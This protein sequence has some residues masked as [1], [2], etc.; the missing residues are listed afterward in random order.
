MGESIESGNVIL[1]SEEIDDLRKA[2][3]KRYTELTGEKIK[4]PERV[5]NSNLKNYWALYKSIDSAVQLNAIG[6][7]STK[8]LAVLFYFSKANRSGSTAFRKKFVDALSIYAFGR[9]RS[10]FAVTK[11]GIVGSSI[12]TTQ[13]K[14]LLGYWECYY[15]KD[16]RFAEIIKTKNEAFLDV[17]AFTIKE[18]EDNVALVEYYQSKNWGTGIIKVQGGNF[19]LQLKS[20]KNHD[21]TFQIMNCGKNIEDFATHIRFAAGISLYINDIGSVKAVK[22]LMR[23]FDESKMLERFNL[24]EIDL[25]NESFRKN[26]QGELKVIA[27]SR[28]DKWQE[29]IQQFFQEG[30]NTTDVH[31]S[32]FAAV[33]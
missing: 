15:D 2:V 19:I 29:K 22:C 12:D 20:E 3:L 27:N 24:S 31:I 18:G 32:D 9:D 10:G 26:F 8:P 6:I 28:E 14:N 1:R 11:T 7:K 25:S 23:Y 33:D 30:F 21:T 4:A 13:L 16:A 5:F 17:I